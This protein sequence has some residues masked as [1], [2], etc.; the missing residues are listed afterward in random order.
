[1]GIGGVLALVFVVILMLKV[2]QDT[3]IQNAPPEGQKQEQIPPLS[4]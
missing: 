3:D 1:M 2:I 4:R